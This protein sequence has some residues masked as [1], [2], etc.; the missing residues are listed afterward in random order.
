MI[1]NRGVILVLAHARPELLNELFESI[2]KLIGFEKVSI[3]VVRQIGNDSVGTTL[4][5]W[6]ELI[7][8]LVE[9]DGSAGTT[10]ENISKNRLAGYAVS[11]DSLGADW[12]LAVEDDVLL[13]PDT[14]LF[15]KCIFEKYHSHR[16]FRAI[17]LGSRLSKSEIGQSTY[18]LTRFGVVGQA[19]VL[20]R[21]TWGKMRRLGIIEFARS[22]LWDPAMEAY[23]KTGFCVA[24]NN[25]RYIDRG[26]VEATHMSSNPEESYYK[27]ISASF[28]QHSESPDTHFKRMDL[29]YWWRADLKKYRYWKNL[30]YW[31]IFASRSP[32]VIRAY[33]KL[34]NF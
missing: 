27:D 1:R 30:F 14:F 20:P 19:S 15:A 18:C 32:F 6:R 24:P 11:F 26:W 23:V 7:E 4:D 8:V 3:V 21:S 25:S 22:G 34:R 13:A 29:G 12:V 31:I 28:N 17:N 16:N 9:T 2:H 5:K 33:R 10:A